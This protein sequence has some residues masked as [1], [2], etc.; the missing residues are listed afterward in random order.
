MQTGDRWSG[1]SP[2]PQTPWAQHR[3]Q[4]QQYQPFPSG[5]SGCPMSLR[6]T[7][8]TLRLGDGRSCLAHS[9]P[10]PADSTPRHAS[11]G[12][13]DTSSWN[14]SEGPARARAVQAFWSQ[15]G[16][17]TDLGQAH[18]GI[19]FPSGWVMWRDRSS[20]G[21]AHLPCVPG[22]RPSLLP[23]SAGAA[24][25]GWGWGSRAD[26]AGGWG[27]GLE[28]PYLSS[29]SLTPGLPQPGDSQMRPPGDL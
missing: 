12:G 29:L 2:A 4:H 17:H 13:R 22:E 27:P 24:W 26:G 5:G 28:E 16:P 7:K 8:G 11:Q 1:G 21:P 10:A 23:G 18:R 15:P 3:H 25:V 9:Q 19:S 14:C 6:C 20:P